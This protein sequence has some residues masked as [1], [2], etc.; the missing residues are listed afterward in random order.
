MPR[1]YTILVYFLK[2]THNEGTILLLSDPKQ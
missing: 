2:F 1:E